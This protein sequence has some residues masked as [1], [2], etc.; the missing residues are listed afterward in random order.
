MDALL[1]PP[2]PKGLLPPELKL[3]GL[4]LSEAPLPMEELCVLRRGDFGLVLLPPPPGEVV[5]RSEPFAFAAAL[6][7]RSAIARVPRTNFGDATGGE[8]LAR[9]DVLLEDPQVDTAVVVGFGA[10][11]G[12]TVARFIGGEYSTL[13]R[14]RMPLAE[15]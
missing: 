13:R 7:W 14:P 11:A 15:C 8:L 6:A 3:R 10:T 4:I 2:P 5:F 1:R 9:P 12:G